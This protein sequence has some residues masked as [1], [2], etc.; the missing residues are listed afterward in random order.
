LKVGIILS[1]SI[2]LYFY[3]INSY[4]NIVLKKKKKDYR[5]VTSVSYMLE[6]AQQQLLKKKLEI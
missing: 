1:R 2:W 5:H 4:L 6:H 3:E